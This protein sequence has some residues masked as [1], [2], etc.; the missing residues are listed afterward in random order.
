MFLILLRRTFYD[1]P[2]FFFFFLCSSPFHQI[3]ICISKGGNGEGNGLW[4]RSPILIAFWDHN[5]RAPEPTQWK[6]FLYNTRVP[7]KTFLRVWTGNP[8]KKFVLSASNPHGALQAVD[9][10]K[11]P[12]T[13]SLL[14]LLRFCS[15]VPDWNATGRDKLQIRLRASEEESGRSFYLAAT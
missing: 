13:H 6:G 7:E 11:M 2:F 1:L 9:E 3:R 10:N 4:K 8:K 12:S 14:H 5:K 15:N